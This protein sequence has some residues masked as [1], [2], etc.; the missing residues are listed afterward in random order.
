[1]TATALEPRGQ[2]SRQA[3][4]PA[5]AYARSDYLVD[6]VRGRSDPAAANRM[7][8]RVSQLTGLDP[9]FVA[10][11]GGKVDFQTFTRELHR[12]QGDVVSVYDGTFTAPDPFPTS[13]ERRSGDPILEGI[14]APVTAAA[15]DFTTRVVGWKVDWRYSALNETISPAWQW[16]SGA[17]GPGGPSVESVS[18]L[19]RAMANDPR[20]KVLLAH[21]FTDLITPYFATQL[22]ID[23][24]P[25]SIGGPDRIRLE[26]YPGGH[27]FYTREGSR[28]ALKR[29]V[30][31]LFAGS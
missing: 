21:G 6:L 2:L 28:A 4:A 17:G 22:I 16:E 14:V 29:D 11:M 5:E 9:R 18:D 1:M 10:R 13:G 31:W 15:V 30:S 25:A 3:L 20:F 12:D 7:A 26:V 24:L 19:R 27:M 23:Q 8:Q